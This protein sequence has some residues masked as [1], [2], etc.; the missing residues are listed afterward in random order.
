MT[1]EPTLAWLGQFDPDDQAAAQAMLQNM[2]LVSRDAFADGLRKLILHRL[3]AG[4]EPVGLYAEREVRHH[5]GIPNRLFKETKKKVKRAFGAGPAPVEATKTYR[6]EVGSE[7][8]VAQIVTELCRERRGVLV[9]HP[10]PDAIR[11]YK[12]RR[13]I[14]LTDFIGSGKR[15]RDY[16]E[17][18]WRVRSVRSWWSSR[19]RTGLSFEV[20][21][22]TA[23]PAGRRLVE[24]HPCEPVVSVVAGSPTIDTLP[25]ELRVSVRGIC[26][27]YDPVD[28]DPIESLGFAGG[29]ALIAFAHGVPNNA[30]RILHKRS[31]RW[32][33]LF[34]ARVTAG[35][36][37]HFADRRDPQAVVERLIRLRQRRLAAGPWLQ[38]ASAQARGLFLTLA[39][40]GRG[41]RFDE[42]L[43]RKTG[44][45]V[46]EVQRWVSFAVEQGWVNSQR[47][48]TDRG[49]AELAQ[50][51][52][53]AKRKISL[54]PKREE[55]YYPSSLREPCGPSS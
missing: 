46:L 25:D 32:A 31:S 11:K 43:S 53:G 4:E 8:L 48:L 14:V 20:I 47:R 27:R 42:V 40:L 23:T 5:K 36:R 17:A 21:A 49:Q 3:A 22:Y 26:I 45:T 7:G 34:P 44:L 9:S 38:G 37:A 6:P 13:F 51:R 54:Q 15:V 18:A 1:S 19:Q 28:H 33:P 24:E 52:E 41:P 30:P 50:A 39:A 12:I 10:G 2:M 16:L 29:G 55:L 35:S